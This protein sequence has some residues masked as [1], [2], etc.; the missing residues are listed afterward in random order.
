MDLKAL[1]V[2]AREQIGPLMRAMA[3]IVRFKTKRGRFQPGRS[4]L[5]LQGTRHYHATKG[6]R[7]GPA[8]G[9]GNPRPT[10][11]KVTT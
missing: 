3:P 6:W 5:L 1:F 8:Y 11:R 2:K 10:L 9:S 7:G 4:V